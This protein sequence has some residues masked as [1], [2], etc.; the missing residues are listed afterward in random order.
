MNINREN[1]EAWFLDYIEGKLDEAEV[2][3]LKA[4]LANNPDLENELFSYEEIVLQPQIHK[5]ENKNELKKSFSEVININTENF[6]EFCIARLEGDLNPSEIRVFDK[7]IDENPSKLN[8]YKLYL[9]TLLEVD[10]SISFPYKSK[11]KHYNVNSNKRSLLWLAS[12]AA[13]ITI[14]VLSY[15][16]HNDLKSDYG[17][18]GISKIE[19]PAKSNSEIELKNQEITKIPGKKMTSLAKENNI[20]ANNKKYIAANFSK[21]TKSNYSIEPQKAMELYELKRPSMFVEPIKP[22]KGKHV[23]E[24]SS[25]KN[26]NKKNQENYLSLKDY[27]VKEIK[28]SFTK[29]N[30]PIEEGLSL[31]ALAKSGVNEL[32]KYTGTKLSLNKSVDSASNRTIVAFNSKLLGFYSSSEKR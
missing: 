6:D 19:V 30:L 28:E 9:K 24:I 29:E 13:S 22:A 27:A 32:N 11:L 18:P 7:F 1:Y 2:A 26:L 23:A 10:K 8:D 20:K 31:W 25:N 12:A 5:L 16:I 21:N 17:G 14:I 4:F 3:G 15:K